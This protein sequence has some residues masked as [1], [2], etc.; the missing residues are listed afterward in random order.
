MIASY[1]CNLPPIA[2]NFDPVSDQ[3]LH[4]VVSANCREREREVGNMEFQHIL[5]WI[6]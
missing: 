2:A 6:A 4:A 1:V 5:P 3:I